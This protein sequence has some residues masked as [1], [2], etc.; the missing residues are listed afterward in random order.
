MKTALTGR[1]LILDGRLVA[2]GHL[3]RDLD[4]TTK[5]ILARVSKGYVKIFD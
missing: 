1:P 5:G 3:G 2:S 4:V